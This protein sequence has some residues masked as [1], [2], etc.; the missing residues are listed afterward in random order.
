MTAA[1]LAA[2]SGGRLVVPC[3]SK[4]WCPETFNGS[5]ATRQLLQSVLPHRDSEPHK[6]D[7]DSHHT[8]GGAS[9]LRTCDGLAFVLLCRSEFE[10]L[11][12]RDGRLALAAQRTDGGQCDSSVVQIQNVD[13]SGLIRAFRCTGIF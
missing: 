9:H 1:T 6:L 8:T 11:K 5:Y 2:W 4:W 12:E 10:Q 13:D 3:A 7:V